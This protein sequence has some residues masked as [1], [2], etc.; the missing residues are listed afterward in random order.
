MI[1]YPPDIHSPGDCTAG[2]QRV[3]VLPQPLACLSHADHLAWHSSEWQASEGGGRGGLLHRTPLIVLCNGC[4]TP[5]AWRQQG[6][7]DSL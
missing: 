1:F 2:H 7:A 3:A 6:S 4:L 5:V